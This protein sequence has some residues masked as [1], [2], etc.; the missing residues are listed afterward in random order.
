LLSSFGDYFTVLFCKYLLLS[1][2][3]LSGNKKAL[4][5]AE[6]GMRLESKTKLSLEKEKDNQKNDIS[7]SYL[8]VT[9]YVYKK[10]EAKKRDLPPSQAP[11]PSKGSL[12]ALKGE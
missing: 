5:G 6:K 1:H 4:E 8:F 12:H 9:I 10:H 3:Y 7:R 11:L 2:S